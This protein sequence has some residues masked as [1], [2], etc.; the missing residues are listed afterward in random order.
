MIS[1]DF[2]TLSYPP[3]QKKI[4]ATVGHYEQMQNCYTKN[5]NAVKQK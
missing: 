4:L 3:I 1:F 5:M 2:Q